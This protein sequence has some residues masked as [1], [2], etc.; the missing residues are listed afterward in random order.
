MANAMLANPPKQ[1]ELNDCW[2]WS[3]SNLLSFKRQKLGRPTSELIRSAVEGISRAVSHP[4]RLSAIGTAC[5]TFD[6]DFS[7]AHDEEVRIFGADAVLLKHLSFILSKKNSVKE[8]D[9]LQLKEEVGYTC[10]VL[11]MICRCNATT[12][13]ESVSNFGNELVEMLLMVISDFKEEKIQRRD[14]VVSWGDLVGTE[15]HTSLTR[16]NHSHYGDDFSVNKATKMLCHIAR[17]GSAI[18]FLAKH[19]GVLSTLKCVIETVN[20]EDGQNYHEARLNCL[21]VIANLACAPENMIYIVRFP[22]LVDTLLHVVVNFGKCHGDFDDEPFSSKETRYRTRCIAARG[23]AVRAF[24]NLSWE[25]E[26]KLL[27]SSNKE[28]LKGLLQLSTQQEETK[29]AATLAVLKT[30]RIHAAGTLRNIAAVSNHE[31][32]LF[33]CQYDQS[34]LITKNLQ[35]CNDES[36]RERIFALFYNLCCEKTKDILS[37]HLSQVLQEN[38]SDTSNIKELAQRIHKFIDTESNTCDKRISDSP[39]MHDED[40]V[41]EE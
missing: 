3:S 34:A 22:G 33:L 37:F 32:K 24:L 36:I 12:L 28:L 15:S 23:Q 7:S 35:S 26:N 31:Q 14:S 4:Q 30:T 17:V 20:K 9:L 11:E 40:Y 8:E 10:S 1:K 39:N 25:E 27:F 41:S 16:L 5:A 38:I 6:H 29:T 19:D 21:F 2:K 18:E 13:C